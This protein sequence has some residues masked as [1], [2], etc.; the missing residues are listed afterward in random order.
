MKK[1][2][3][4]YT[5]LT[6]LFIAWSCKQEVIDLQ[7]PD[8]TETETHTPGTANFS[9]FVALGSSFTAGFQA[10]A[11]F[12]EGQANSLPA[13]M[14]K[15]FAVNGVGGGSFKQP[16]INA[17]LGYN[18]F[19]SPNPGTDGRV[20]GRM[21]LQGADPVP[22]P[23]KYALGDLS[24]VPNP[25]PGVNPGFMYTGS[26]TELGNFAVEAITL[27]QFLTPA[28][29]NWGNPNPAVGFSPFYARFAS[30]PGTSTIMSDAVA[31]G[32]SFFMFWGGMDDFLL[33]AAFGG[34]AT[35]APLT[36]TGTF[37]AYYG[38]AVGGLLASNASL[39][40]VVANFPD[41]FLMPHF[42][43]V[44]YNPIPL[45]LATAT[46]VGGGF[47]GYNAAL[48]GLIANAA[49]FGISPSL[50]AE[51]GT[52]KVTFAAVTNNAIL[53]VDETLTDLGP[54]FDGLQGAGAI[55][56]SQR[57]QLGPYQRVRQT[58]S[59]DII[60]LSAGSILGTLV[61]GNPQ[62][63]NGVSV[64]LADQY[65]LIPSEIA[66]ITA[67]RTAFNATIKS[68][69]NANSD[70]VAFADVDAAFTSFFSSQVLVMN[71][72]SIWP[73]IDPPAGIFSEDGLHP[74][75]RGYAYISTIF[76]AAINEKFAA[77][78]PLTDISLYQATG[79]PIP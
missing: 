76:I 71:G 19:I 20:V 1:H 78:V 31:A 63:V 57:A 61:D 38:A 52:R 79:L 34:D 16:D 48:D 40:G 43:A 49:A 69:A 42:T 37:G 11:L 33:Y 12:D 60:P 5:A 10:G 75:S 2:R 4:I 21:L 50:A 3:L 44:P 74:N 66:A 62:L 47:A 8:G 46:V 17:S 18:I 58:T 26:K 45:D 35:K 6:L 14:A 32:G 24:A 59:T 28:T 72:V 73:K 13:I 55:S 51:I 53:I 41:I 23:Q 30:N 56:A 27:G 7:P 25:S 65:V 68:F 77:K 9:K 36:N 54:Y 29:G 70:R 15:Q 22:T 67:A 64:P 39:K